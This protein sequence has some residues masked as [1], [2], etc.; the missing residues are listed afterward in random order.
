MSGLYGVLVGA[1]GMVADQSGW[2]LDG[3][4]L[5]RRAVL[6]DEQEAILC[7]ERDD[8]H[9]SAGVGALGILPASTP[10]ELQPVSV[11]KRMG[12]GHRYLLP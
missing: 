4:A 12:F 1:V 9:A 6:F 2:H 10:L 8:H 11:A 5:D 3:H 7:G